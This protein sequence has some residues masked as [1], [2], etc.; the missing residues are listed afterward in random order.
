MQTLRTLANDGRSVVVVTHNT[1][2]L[3]LCDKLLILAP[4]GRLAYFGPPQ[5]ALTY[6]NC[7]DFADLFTMLEQDTSTDWT[8][9]FNTSPLKQ[10]LTGP[11]PASQPPQPPKPPS[12]PPAQQSAFSQFVTLCRRYLAVIAADRLYLATLLLLPLGVSLM[13]YAVPGKAGMSLTKAIEDIQ[14]SAGQ[15][16]QLLVLL[17]I[18]GALM[19]LS[20]LDPRDRQGTGDLSTRTRHRLVARRLH[21]L[22]VGGADRA[23]Q[24]CR[25]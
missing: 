8:G 17:V 4:G 14:K 2:Q 12:K 6:F 15:P 13:A 11:Q 3:N 22:Q 24:P 19:G 23:D 16:A 7:T 18:G 5:Q 10:A 25:G 9:R 1:N 20:R 21:V